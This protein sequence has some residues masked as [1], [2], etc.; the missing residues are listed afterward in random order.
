[1]ATISLSVAT[2]DEKIE[3]TMRPNSDKVYLQQLIAEGEH[4]Q[5]DFKFE[6]SDARKIARSLSAFSNTDG[7][8]LLIGVKDNGRIAGVR[9]E[10]EIYMIEAAA[11]LYCRP[12]VEISVQ[13]YEV[14]GKT[15][16]VAEIPK[17]EQKPVQVQDETGKY[18]AYV[19]I[20]DENILATPVHLA[21]WRQ[22]N[23]AQGTLVKYTEREQLLLDYLAEHQEITVS[24]YSRLAHIS[25]RLAIEYIARFVRFGI[26]DICFEHHRFCYRLSREG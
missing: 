14:D 21:V 12:N 25:Y 16:L 15:V 18:L 24:K 11:K 22:K 8:R 20:A 3:K 23:S 9:S 6:I 2:V 17:A 4:Q 1:M 7:G 26:L 10:E 19:R 13:T 5:Q